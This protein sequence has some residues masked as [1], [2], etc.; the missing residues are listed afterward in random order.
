MGT[1]TLILSRAL[2]FS[3]KT[4]FETLDLYQWIYTFFLFSFIYNLCLSSFL[5]YNI[6]R[7][8]NEVS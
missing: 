2:S 5:L 8:E 7:K 3:L 6:L 4:P 1:N